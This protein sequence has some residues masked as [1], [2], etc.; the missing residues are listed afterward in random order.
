MHTSGTEK[1]M[2]KK[3][4]CPNCET[5]MEELPI[6]IGDIE[7]GHDYEC[8]TCHYECDDEEQTPEYDE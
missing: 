1:S 3:K 2:S 4:N 5:V 6:I 7:I 8:P